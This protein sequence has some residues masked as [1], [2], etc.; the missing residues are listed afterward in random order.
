MGEALQCTGVARKAAV[1][2]VLDGEMPTFTAG[3]THSRI[4]QLLR[5]KDADNLL[6]GKEA[7]AFRRRVGM[8]AASDQ[9]RSAAKGLHHR[10][11]VIARRNV[12]RLSPIG[13][14]RS[15]DFRSN[16]SLETGLDAPG[17]ASNL[18]ASRGPQSFGSRS[19]GKGA[20]GGRRIFR[21]NISYIHIFT[22]D[23]SIL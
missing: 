21:C 7:P 3:S 16:P 8:Q 4:S 17:R 10:T 1:L 22:V 2:A 9:P 14:R 15:F 18:E 6:R 20:S 19:R 12:G 5:A 23:S 13:E 11:R